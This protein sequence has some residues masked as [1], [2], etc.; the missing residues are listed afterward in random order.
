MSV[1]EIQDNRWEVQASRPNFFNI[2]S[3]GAIL[4]MA[5]LCVFFLWLIV[6]SV[7][8]FFTEPSSLTVD[9]DA[10]KA[11]EGQKAAE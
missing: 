3:L 6:G 10:A 1:A 8:G 11:A 5:G 9:K 4:M 2:G 7:R